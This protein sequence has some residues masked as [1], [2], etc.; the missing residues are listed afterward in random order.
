MYRSYQWY[1]LQE[2][3]VIRI[4]YRQTAETNR[5]VRLIVYVEEKNDKQMFVDQYF[6]FTTLWH[7]QMRLKNRIWFN[8]KIIKIITK[9]DVIYPQQID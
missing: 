8:M 1:K 9:I 5:N 6:D 7:R 4:S 2:I 3:I